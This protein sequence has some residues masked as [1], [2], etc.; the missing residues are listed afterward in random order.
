VCADCRRP[1]TEC[2]CREKTATGA[3]GGRIVRVGRETKG[4]R[5]KGVTVIAGLPLSPGE[6]ADL[7]RELKKKCGSGG[8]V[9]DGAIE[10]QGEHRDF[11]VE[12][13]TRRGFRAKR[14]GG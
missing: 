10:I 11:V 6:L 4:R 8:T 1:H 9:R 2:R 7:A 13:L 12:E 3:V 5:G 14:S